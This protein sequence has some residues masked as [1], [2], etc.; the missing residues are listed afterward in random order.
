METHRHLRSLTQAVCPPTCS[1]LQPTCLQPL[2]GQDCAVVLG[3][4]SGLITV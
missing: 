1:G 2:E 3:D 4:R